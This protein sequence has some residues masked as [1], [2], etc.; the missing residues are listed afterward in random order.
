MI[1][2]L[3][4]GLLPE[5]SLRRRLA[6]EIARR[7]PHSSC[8]D[9]VRLAHLAQT[10]HVRDTDRSFDIVFLASAMGPMNEGLLREARSALSAVRRGDVALQDLDP[11]IGA[12]VAE[13]C[14]AFDG[15][16]SLQI[17]ATVH[18]AGGAWARRFEPCPRSA[19]PI[20]DPT[21]HAMRGRSAYDGPPITDRDM[22]A[23]LL[24]A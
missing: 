13:A 5:P 12:A 20:S 9:V 14:A 23:A 19:L 2:R 7:R 1:G 18:R 17:A 4:R 22:V 15:A 16:T 8:L 21:R 10:A 11:A 24:A 6:R 3:L